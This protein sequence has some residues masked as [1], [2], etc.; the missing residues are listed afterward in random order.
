METKVPGFQD[1]EIF[2]CRDSDTD[3]NVKNLVEA[4]VA[5][6]TLI[7]KKSFDILSK[8]YCD[9]INSLDQ[10]IA[11]E[12]A[13]FTNIGKKEPSLSKIKD[14]QKNAALG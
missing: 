11:D 7:S 6:L 1:E 3:K 4:F 2:K 5:K 10:A 14:L 9:V 13:Y 12:V 8:E